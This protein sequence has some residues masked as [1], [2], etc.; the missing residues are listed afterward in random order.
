WAKD[1]IE[2]KPEPAKAKEKDKGGDKEKEAGGEDALRTRDDAFRRLLEV[3]DFFRR[4]EPQSVVPHALEQVVRWGRMSLPE[5]LVELIPEEAP[6]KGLFKQVGIR[7]PE[8]PPKPEGAK[9]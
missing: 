8:P 7:P 9:K 5:L 6:R 4:T 2:Q 1:R 3:A